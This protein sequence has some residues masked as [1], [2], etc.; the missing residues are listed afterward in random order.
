MA[1]ARLAGLEAEVRAGCVAVFGCCGVHKKR[2]VIGAVFKK[3]AAVC[4]GQVNYI[5][6]LKLQSV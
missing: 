3:F 6:D 1:G 5:Q 4:I 2:R